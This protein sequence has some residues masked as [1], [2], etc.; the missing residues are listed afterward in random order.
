MQPLRCSPPVAPWPDRSSQ[1]FEVSY[2]NAEQMADL[3]KRDS[4]RWQK[5][6]KD[7]GLKLD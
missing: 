3:I 7:I 2:L 4:V 6:I 1:G 5:S